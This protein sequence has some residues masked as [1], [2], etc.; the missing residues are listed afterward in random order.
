MTDISDAE[1]L[2]WLRLYRSE[3]IGPVTFRQLLNRYETAD[4]ALDAI[5]ELARRAGG[6]RSPRLADLRSIER[7]WRAIEAAGAT[8]LIAKGPRF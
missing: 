4:R 5:P 7:E 2:A 3:R 8:L 6:K 1:R